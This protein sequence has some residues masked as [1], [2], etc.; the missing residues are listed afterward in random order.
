VK[1]FGKPIE[2]LSL[3]ITREVKQTSKVNILENN[4]PK[5]LHHTVK[6]NLHVGI[7]NW[8]ELPDTPVTLPIFTLPRPTGVDSSSSSS[9]SDADGSQL[10]SVGSEACEADI[11]A[12]VEELLRPGTSCKSSQRECKQHLTHH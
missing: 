11:A 6:Q 7:L 4:F 8:K 3:K 1:R 12:V 5:S 2:F 9:A 10:L